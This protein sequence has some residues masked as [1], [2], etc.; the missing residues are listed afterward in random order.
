[1]T[2]TSR[3]S[4]EVAAANAA[5]RTPILLI[6]GLWMLAGGWEPWRGLLEHEGYAVVAA[7]WPGDAADVRAAREDASALAG[8]S[9]ATVTEH[10][11]ELASAF[12]RRPVVI[13]HS[14][15]G[16]V[17]QQIAGRGI[18]AACVA[19]DPAPMRGVLPMPLSAIRGSLPVL[20]DP[21]NINRTV[22]LTFDQFRYVFANTVE[23]TEARRLYDA[24]HVPAP[25]KPLF[26]AAAA[27]ID[28]RSPLRVDVRN[29]DRGPLLVITGEK[30][31]IVPFAMSSAT[32][33]RQ[34]RNPCPTEL[35]EIPDAGHSLVFDDH[36]TEVAE[37]ALGFLRR[38]GL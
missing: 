26:Q 33:R 34:R 14:F 7:D 9:I 35:V 21:R 38:H 28:P 11:V 10:M 3:E 4:A 24:V 12:D 13:G 32:Y 17:A 2:L 20:A 37:A 22:L 6:H 29:P 36:R 23:E 31:T 27:N 8:L 19:I 5:V 16:L 15:G 30:D 1:M 18:A 25:A